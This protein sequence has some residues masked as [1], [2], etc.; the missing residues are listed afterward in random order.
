LK[1]GGANHLDKAWAEQNL[2]RF[3]D[4][5]SFVTQWV[6]RKNVS[7][8]KHF[9]PQYKFVC[10]PGNLTPKVEFI[11]YFER[12][13]DDFAYIKNRLGS[14][15][16]LQH[17][18]KTGGFKRDFKE[19]YTQETRDL[20]AEVY[21]EDIR[22]FGYDFENAFLEDRTKSRDLEPQEINREMGY[23]QAVGEKSLR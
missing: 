10:E 6:N 12:L 15:S 22:L 7:T 17:L 21:R 18:N 4:F 8:W 19:Y 13:E 3:D 16:S 14:S 9:V 5:H 1:K 2:S 20:V 23:S 11:G